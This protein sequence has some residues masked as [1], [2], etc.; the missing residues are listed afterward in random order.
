MNADPA[1][2]QSADACRTER[3]ALTNDTIRQIYRLAACADAKDWDNAK[4]SFVAAASF[5][6]KTE[7]ALEREI[8]AVRQGE[9]SSEEVHGEAASDAQVEADDE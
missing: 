7:K 8:E 4:R 9:R 5:L 2:G 1:G 3:V 6:S